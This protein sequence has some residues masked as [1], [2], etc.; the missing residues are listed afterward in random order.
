MPLK[1]I[2]VSCFFAALSICASSVSAQ[3]SGDPHTD[4]SSI[5][6]EAKNRMPSLSGAVMWL[7]STPQS[8]ELLR[9]KVVLVDFW[10]YDCINCKNALPYV[11]AWSKKYANDGLV[12]IGVHTPEYSYEKL[13][14]NVRRQVTQLDIRYPVAIDNNYKIWRAFD[15]QYW[16]AHY[17]IDAKGAVRYRH[18]GEGGY[19]KQEE[20]IQ[21]LLEEAK[22][23][24]AATTQF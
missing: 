15:N 10:T 9:G 6:L 19:A 20:M 22:A 24:G 12:V 13:I 7:N 3:T 5:D 8:S 2:Y 11:N 17:I 4:G 21:K 1:T 16:P 14:D 23:D 18:F